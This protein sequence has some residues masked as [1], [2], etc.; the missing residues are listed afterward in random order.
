M[1]RLTMATPTLDTYKATVTRA[2]KALG[3]ELTWGQMTDLLLDNHSEI[4]DSDHAHEILC[5]IL[6]RELGIAV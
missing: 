6:D 4:R 3:Y 1:V 2:H 5:Q